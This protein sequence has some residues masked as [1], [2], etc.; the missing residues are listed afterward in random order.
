M[1]SLNWLCV[2][3]SFKSVSKV[4][5]A[6]RTARLCSVDTKALSLCIV[7][8]IDA[9]T[10]KWLDRNLFIGEEIKE[11]YEEI[12]KTIGTNHLLF[13]QVWPM[14]NYLSGI[15]SIKLI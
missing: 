12:T 2:R 15:V 4:R 14:T 11:V 3:I 8:Q 13:D 1:F 6:S 5:N 10:A 9:P 7:I